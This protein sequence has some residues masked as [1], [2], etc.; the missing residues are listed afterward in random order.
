MA[1]EFYECTRVGYHCE[2]IVALGGFMK[3]PKDRS[4]EWERGH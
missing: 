3:M 2:V 4:W 1:S